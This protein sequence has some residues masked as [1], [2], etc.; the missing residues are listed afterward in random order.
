[1]LKR[2]KIS[3]H[4]HSGRIKPHEYTSYIPLALLLI[5]TGIGLLTYT[6]NATRPGPEA[7]SISLG[8]SMP[9]KPPTVAA[10][11]KT[12]NS[13]Q[14]FSTSP[15]EFTGTCPANTL[16]ELYKNDIFAGSSPCTEAGIFKMDIDLL[17]GQ[18]IIIARVYDALNQA[19]PDSN[20]VTVYYDAMPSQSSPL[21][22]LDF[23]SAQ[24]LINTDAVFRGTFPN[25]ELSIPIDIIGGTPPFAVN[26]QWG[27]SSNKV[28]SRN[29]NTTFSA[30]HIY[31]KAG[32]YQITIQASDALGRVAFLTVASIVNG[33]PD[34]VAT[35]SSIPTSEVNKLL[36]LWPLYVGAIAV[37]ISFWIGEQR[38]KKILEKRGLLIHT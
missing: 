12:P 16:V 31:K 15:I 3:H 13:Q 29:N 22:T 19:G 10:V 7:S 14:H 32:T 6:A 27:D 11:I 30:T 38:E 24:M 35:A 9:G 4:S 18:N 26:I 28:V 36:V 17:N 34:V 2:L 21:S 33:Q 20:P 1:M 25:H 37:L 8:G 23:G 5:A